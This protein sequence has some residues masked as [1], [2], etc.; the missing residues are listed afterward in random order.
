MNRMTHTKTARAKADRA[1]PHQA[2]L[3][4]RTLWR[5]ENEMAAAPSL[6]DLAGTENVRPE[7]LTRVFALV[8]GQ[9][10][11][12]YTRTRRLSE[13][14]RRLLSSDDSVLNVAL[15]TGYDSH[16]GFAR[17]F[18]DQFGVSPSYLRKAPETELALQDPIEMTDQELPTVTP[19]FKD[20]PGARLTG[21]SRRFTFADR[22][23]IPGLWEEAINLIGDPMF[24]VETFGVCHNFAEDAFD[25][26]VVY[27]GGDDPNAPDRVE[28]PAGRYA[29][30][31]HEGHISEIDRTWTAI[32]E[33]WSPN[34]DVDLSG[35]P[36]FE[37]Y[38]VDFDVEKPGGVAIW[39]P[40]KDKA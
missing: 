2:T 10:V 13:A 8:T 32:F 34:A 11:M 17:A 31:H 39:I 33:S 37:R 15:D 12:A 29:V 28:I 40:V 16:E 22:A 5:I 3:V 19:E 27:D 36:E 14:A 24:G 30:F 20:F 7:H 26:A 9:T 38:A 6:V 23:K 1:K 25:Y 18:R 4:R 21:L 35:G